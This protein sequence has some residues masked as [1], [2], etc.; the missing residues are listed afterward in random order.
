MFSSPK[1]AQGAGKQ[2]PGGQSAEQRAGN[3]PAL[4]RHSGD[5]DHE[6]IQPVNATAAH[7]ESDIAIGEEDQRQGRTQGCCA[8]RPVNASDQ[9]QTAAEATARDAFYAVVEQRTKCRSHVRIRGAE[10]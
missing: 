3:A 6:H 7:L 10:R 5:D 8:V 2:K 9:E 1:A 4:G